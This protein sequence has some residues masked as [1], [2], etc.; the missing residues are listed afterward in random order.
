MSRGVFG[1]TKIKAYTKLTFLLS[2]QIFD[3]RSE[4]PSSGNRRLWT[5]LGILK[6]KT[7]SRM[8][9]RPLWRPR[10]NVGTGLIKGIFNI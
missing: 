9:I 2:C 1:Q 8:L 10:L 4:A 5:R 7:F 3:R 6:K